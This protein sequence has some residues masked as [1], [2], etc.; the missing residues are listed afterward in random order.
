MAYTY[1]NIVTEARNAGVLE[2]FTQEDHNAAQRNPEYGMSLV[3]LL[4][5]ASNATSEE[6]RLLAIESANQLRRSYGTTGAAGAT[7]R[8][9][10]PEAGRL[11]APEKG[12][13]LSGSDPTTYQTVL[14]DIVNQ[15]EFTYNPENDPTYDVYAKAYEREGR[16]ASANALAQAAAM[17]GGRPSSTAVMAAQQAGNYYASQ[18]ADMIPTLRQNAFAE[19]Q[20][21][22]DAKY[23]I[24]GALK[25]RQDTEYQKTLDEENR[26]RLAVQDALSKYQ[27]LGY[28]TPDVAAILGVPEGIPQTGSTVGNQQVTENGKTWY[29]VGSTKLTQ[30]EIDEAIAKNMIVRDY[31]PATGKVTYTWMPGKEAEYGDQ[32]DEKKIGNPVS[33]VN[34]V[35]MYDVGGKKLTMQQIAQYAFDGSITAVYNAATNTV[36]YKW[37]NRNNGFA[38]G[39]RLEHKAVY[40]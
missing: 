26:K 32:P 10:F 8:S 39:S 16:R 4:K 24:L 31:D 19:Y 2:K 15:K 1:D 35:D 37:S 33:K 21:D 28:A 38:G 27:I 18:L 6:Q 23:D 9:S 14:N 20:S 40:T 3:A 36:T 25:D 30:S 7:V 13:T 17:S 5:D 34:G 12:G 29:M 11:V 22:I